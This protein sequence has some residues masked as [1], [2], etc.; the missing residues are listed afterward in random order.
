MDSGK[1]LT[2]WSEVNKAL[3]KKLRYWLTDLG[4]ISKVD[5]LLSCTQMR[6]L[7]K[8]AAALWTLFSIATKPVI[9]VFVLYSSPIDKLIAKGWIA[10]KL[11]RL[12]QSTAMK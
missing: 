5:T 3:I 7:I 4:A 10:N 2:R 11:R 1:R 12:L 6:V 9:A 8:R